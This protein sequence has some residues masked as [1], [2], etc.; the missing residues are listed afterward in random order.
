[1]NDNEINVGKAILALIRLTL[2]FGFI[3]VVFFL[4]ISG[5]TWVICWGFDKVWSW[6]V[7]IGATVLMGLVIFTLKVGNS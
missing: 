3:A 4:I 1:M 5:L 7:A 6:K 2:I